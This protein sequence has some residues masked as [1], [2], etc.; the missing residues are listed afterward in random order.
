M[1]SSVTFVVVTN[2]T[3]APANASLC[4]GFT[5]SEPSLCNLRSAVAYCIQL[6]R[7]ETESQCVIEL[8]AMTNI[9]MDPHLGELSIDISPHTN[10]TE[11][12]ASGL[13]VVI[14]GQGA[15]ISPL[16]VDLYNEDGESCVDVDVSLYDSYGDGKAEEV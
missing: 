14:D 12:P 9:L 5:T 10:I 6:E 15:A 3:D 2:V 16:L 7:N 13:N 1:T 4:S 11:L 8:P